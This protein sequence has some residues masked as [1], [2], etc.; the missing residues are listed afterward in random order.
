M[1]LLTLL[2]FGVAVWALVAWAFCSVGAKADR[3]DRLHD[4]VRELE[5]AEWRRDLE[6]NRLRFDSATSAIERLRS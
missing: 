4:R 6:A 3:I 1:I 2:A 5:R